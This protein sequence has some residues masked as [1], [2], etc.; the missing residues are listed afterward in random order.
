VVVFPEHSVHRQGHNFM[1]KGRA[2]SEL[3]T[4][5]KIKTIG[6][7]HS[8]WRPIIYWAKWITKCSVFFAFI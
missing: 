5:K 3:R 2:P 7:C 8:L 4:D 6:F 1:L